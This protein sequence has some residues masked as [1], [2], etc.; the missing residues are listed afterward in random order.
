MTDLMYRQSQYETSAAMASVEA[1][2]AELSHDVDV[3]AGKVQHAAQDA[4]NAAAVS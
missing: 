1:S 3:N 4:A 2:T